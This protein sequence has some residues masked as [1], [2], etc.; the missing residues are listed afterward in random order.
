[1][2]LFGEIQSIIYWQKN[3]F[4][5]NKVDFSA[6]T[7]LTG[8]WEI[9]SDH[10]CQHGLTDLSFVFVTQQPTMWWRLV[11]TS[12]TAIPWKRWP[13]TLTIRQAWSF[14]VCVNLLFACMHGV[15]HGPGL[16]KQEVASWTVFMYA[17]IYLCISLFDDLRRS[18]EYFTYTPRIGA[19][20]ERISRPT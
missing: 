6:R 19:V 15:C 5:Q 2:K 8:P 14:E 16:D 11:L 1:M 13:Q 18:Q 9:S 12:L 3:Q 10:T 7:L 17:L 20:P 4:L